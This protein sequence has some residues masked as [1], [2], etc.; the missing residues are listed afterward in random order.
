MQLFWF[1]GTFNVYIWGTT[2]W[3]SL[4]TSIFGNSNSAANNFRSRLPS[5]LSFR[6]LWLWFNLD[7]TGENITKKS[8]S[9]KALYPKACVTLRLKWHEEAS[10]ALEYTIKIHLADIFQLFSE[11]PP[12]IFAR[13]YLY[14]NLGTDI[15]KIL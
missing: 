7:T 3:G 15:Q 5:R 10:D 13:S 2:F 9:L 6:F 11:S 12:S 8:H 14:N 1:F 4:G